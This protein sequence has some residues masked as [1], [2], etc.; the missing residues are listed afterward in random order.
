MEEQIRKTLHCASLILSSL[1]WHMHTA[2]FSVFYLF[3][4][5]F[6]YLYIDLFSCKFSLN[7]RAH[8]VFAFC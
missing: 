3:I 6:I 5:L 4:Y 1:K 7:P 2:H 8:T